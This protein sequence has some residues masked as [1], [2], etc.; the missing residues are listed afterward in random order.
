MCLLYL[1]NLLKRLEIDY[2][3]FIYKVNFWVFNLSIIVCSLHVVILL[4]IFLSGICV[5]I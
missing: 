1:I 2:L 5:C 4:F 3:L